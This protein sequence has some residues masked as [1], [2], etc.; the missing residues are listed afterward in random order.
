MLLFHP[1]AS[2]DSGLFSFSD[3]KSQPSYSSPRGSLGPMKYGTLSCLKPNF[4][5]TLR[6][7]KEVRKKLLQTFAQML[8]N[9]HMTAINS[10][11]VSAFRIISFYQK[12]GVSII[13]SISLRIL[14]SFCDCELLNY[15]NIHFPTT[16][17]DHRSQVC[18]LLC[19]RR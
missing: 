18:R 16:Q 14:T 17:S 5:L 19:H 3:V 1:F 9:E 7:I 8:E 13:N 15:S 6:H 11:D 10:K 4:I 2:P 12:C